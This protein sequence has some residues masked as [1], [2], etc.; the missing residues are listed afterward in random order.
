MNGF[1]EPTARQPSGRRLNQ[2]LHA[3]DEGRQFKFTTTDG[4]TVDHYDDLS[5]EGYPT[6]VVHF[7]WI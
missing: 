4:Q 7:G 3:A 1:P 6:W 2:E 5:P